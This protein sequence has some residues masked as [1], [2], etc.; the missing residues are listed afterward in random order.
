MSRNMLLDCGS[1]VYCNPLST[2]MAVIIS[3]FYKSKNESVGPHD[4][5]IMF[6]LCSASHRDSPSY[7]G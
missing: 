2:F 6:C 3:Q 5:P 7:S 1:I 4:A